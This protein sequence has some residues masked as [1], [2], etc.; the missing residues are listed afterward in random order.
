MI[1]FASGATPGDQF[2][3]SIAGGRNNAFV[4][5]NEG[6]VIVG[7]TAG[8]GD[9]RGYVQALSRQHLELLW[10]AQGEADQQLGVA[11]AKLGDVD[12]DG[13]ADVLVGTDPRTLLGQPAAPG[14]V[15]LLSGADGS[16]IRAHTDGSLGSGYGTV[17]AALGDVTGDGVPDLGVGAP[18]ADAN[19]LDS[20]TAHLYSGADGA[21]WYTIHGPQAGARFGAALAYADDLNG[22]GSPD[23]AVGAPGDAAG[24]GRLY[25]LSV[26]RWKDASSGL[27]G[28][29]GI[30]RLTGEGGLIAQTQATLTLSAARPVTA[31]TLVLGGALV[32]DAAS[33]T[34]M[35]TAEMVTAGLLTGTDGTLTYSF[36]WPAGL[37]SGTTVY[38]QYL[39]SDPAAAGGLARSNSVAATVP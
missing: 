14:S 23:C 29:D 36:T 6:D 11:V 19:G 28:V 17:V 12:G 35:P 7:A 26:S 38:Y 16:L 22:D 25:V 2:G 4:G 3:I 39:I 5:D 10:Q 1:A 37:V 20:G 15:R 8:G 32:V 9:R 30:P 34:L 31:A 33:G 24:C 13:Q 18:R 27:P 21:S